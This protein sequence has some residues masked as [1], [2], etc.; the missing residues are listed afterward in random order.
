MVSISVYTTRT[1]L[2]GHIPITLIQYVSHIEDPIS[3]FTEAIAS[4]ILI[5]LSIRFGN[6]AVEN[7]LFT[8]KSISEV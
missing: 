3:D 7:R 5:R 2:C 6:V 8:Y 1:K 4:T